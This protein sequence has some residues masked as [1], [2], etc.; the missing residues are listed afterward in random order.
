MQGQSI[1]TR[2]YNSKMRALI[3]KLKVMKLLNFLTE[4]K[5]QEIVQL[6]KTGSVA[7]ANNPYTSIFVTETCLKYCSS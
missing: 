7:A 4:V 3:S 2:K 6:G 1:K 5:L